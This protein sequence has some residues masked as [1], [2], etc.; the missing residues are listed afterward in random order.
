MYTC[1]FATKRCTASPITLSRNY[2]RLIWLW[3]RHL[4][5]EETLHTYTYITCLLHAQG[6]CCPLLLLYWPTIHWLGHYLQQVH[7]YGSLHAIIGLSTVHKGMICPTTSSTVILCL[8]PW[9]PAH[10][11]R[12]LG[13]SNVVHSCTFN[14]SQSCGHCHGLIRWADSQQ[15]GWQPP[16]AY[17][18]TLRR[19][20]VKACCT[21]PQAAESHRDYPHAGWKQIQRPTISSNNMTYGKKKDWGILIFHTQKHPSPWTQNIPSWYT[22]TSFCENQ[23]IVYHFSNV[24]TVWIT[25][26]CALQQKSFCQASVTKEK[27]VMM[28]CVVMQLLFVGYRIFG[29][30]HLQTWAYWMSTSSSKSTYNCDG[31]YLGKN[32]KA[33]VSSGKWKQQ[34]A[35]CQLLIARIS[36]SCLC[37]LLHLISN[38]VIN[39]S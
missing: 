19:A 9:R 21:F 24:S 5:F 31:K 11:T 6:V 14:F 8:A 3:K 33:S 36:C 35:N 10:Y 2:S 39:L 15:F 23:G 4:L 16:S 34:K 28:L 18:Q 27:T 32:V 13:K 7:A 17:R 38:V 12:Y 22:N 1:I 29:G 37:Q 25:F 26:T 20:E 30:F